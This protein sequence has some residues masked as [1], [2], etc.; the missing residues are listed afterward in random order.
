M[1]NKHT[2]VRD[3]VSALSTLSPTTGTNV[4]GGV[5]FEI[6]LK[7]AVHMN[8]Y[9]K[10]A[11]AA[12][13][14]CQAWSQLIDVALGCGGLAIKGTYIYMYIHIYTYI[15]MYIFI[16]LYICICICICL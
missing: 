3:E 16:Y 8:C 4:I 7:A 15:C 6:A 11:A 14:L 10:H 13:Y 9:N 2:Q 1:L 5:E 12:S